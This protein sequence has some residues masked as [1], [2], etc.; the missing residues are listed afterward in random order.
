MKKEQ[1]LTDEIKELN[2]KGS[3]IVQE[4]IELNEKVNLLYQEKIGLQKK[5]YGTGGRNEA[6]ETPA[7]NAISNGYNFI[8]L[9]LRQPQGQRNYTSSNAMKLGLQLHYKAD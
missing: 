6:N 7:T 3:I 4:N 5:V 8:N 2:R 9:Q 1:T